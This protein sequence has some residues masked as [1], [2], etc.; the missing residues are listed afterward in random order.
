M[1]SPK[2]KSTSKKINR[3]VKAYVPELRTLFYEVDK[4]ADYKPHIANE[5]FFRNIKSSKIWSLKMQ[6]VDLKKC[7]IVVGFVGYTNVKGEKTTKDSLY[8]Y[9][10]VDLNVWIDL[11]KAILNG[12]SVGTCVGRYL[13]NKVEVFDNG[14]PT[15]EKVYPYKFELWNDEKQDWELG[16]EWI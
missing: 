6:R 9:L 4:F 2:V 1:S 11:R 10:E 5:E 3:K 15:G 14:L 7:V 8:R 13:S 16:K 12:S